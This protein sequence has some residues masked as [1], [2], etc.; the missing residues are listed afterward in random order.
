MKKL[1]VR[2]RTPGFTLVELLVVIAIIGILVA[3]L[4]P[5]VQAAREAARRMQCSNNLKQL[6][7]ATHNFH[8]TYKRLPPG[9]VGDH[10]ALFPAMYPTA[11][12]DRNRGTCLGPL[13]YILPFMEQQALYDQISGIMEMDVDLPPPTPTGAKRRT[14]WNGTTVVNAGLTKLRAYVCPSMQRKDP[15]PVGTV[16]GAVIY[17]YATD[18]LTLT[19]WGFAVSAASTELGRTNYF[20][21]MG[22]IG[23]RNEDPGWSKF[24]G[25]FWNRSKVNFGEVVDGTSNTFMVGEST[26]LWHA[27]PDNRKL[28]FTHCWLG[29]GQLPTGWGLSNTPYPTNPQFSSF[30]PGVVQFTMLDGSIRTIAVTVD[31]TDFVRVSGRQ[32]AEPVADQQFQQ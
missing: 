30:H 1:I 24:Y 7:V 29:A 5:A 23:N 9:Y 10:P 3:L 26:G 27:A 15:E 25:P 2:Q 4:L 13:T 8:D 16:P 6:G 32:D 20:F 11:T 14:L 28:R 31:F 18:A 22:G 17:L 19:P 12:C 21:N